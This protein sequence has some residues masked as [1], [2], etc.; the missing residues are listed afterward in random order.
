MAAGLLAA[1]TGCS[2]YRSF[3]NRGAPCAA[4]G[5]TANYA[6]FEEYDTGSTMSVPATPYVSPSPGM[7]YPSTPGT[8]TPRPQ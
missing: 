2:E 4:T 8:F 1:Q 7:T 3:C 6:P 5:A